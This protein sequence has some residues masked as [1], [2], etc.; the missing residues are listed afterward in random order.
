MRF[1]PQGPIP[2]AHPRGAG[3]KVKKSEA[4]ESIHLKDRLPWEWFSTLGLK[5]ACGLLSL[6]L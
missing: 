5:Q 1:W 4:G 2:P 3:D 6:R